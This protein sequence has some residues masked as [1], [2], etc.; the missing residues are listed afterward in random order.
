MGGLGLEF[1]SNSWAQ[2][3]QT[4]TCPFKIIASDIFTGHTKKW[5]YV[6]TVSFKK[7]P[8]RST[9]L[10]ISIYCNCASVFL[11]VSS[12]TS[13]LGE[14]FKCIFR[15]SVQPMLLQALYINCPFSLSGGCFLLGLLSYLSVELQVFFFPLYLLLK[16]WEK[17]LGHQ[18]MWCWEWKP[19]LEGIQ[20]QKLQIYSTL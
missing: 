13:Q 15:V 14:E 19:R 5:N 2:R 9:S 16:C 7:N 20:P 17:G 6:G 12:M 3:M 10:K 11:I 18:L 4:S 1:D 8:L